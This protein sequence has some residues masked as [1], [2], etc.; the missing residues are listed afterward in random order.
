[1]D[2]K[3]NKTN[4]PDTSRRKFMTK[5]ALGAGATAAAVF[6]ERT[7]HAADS[8]EAKPIKVPEEF[9][10]ATKVAPVKPNFPMT[11]AQV[12]ARVCKEEG[13]A[14]LFCCPGNYPIQNA[15]A[16]EGIPTYSGRHEGGMCHA[17]DGF[18]RVTGLL[19]PHRPIHIS[20]HKSGGAAPLF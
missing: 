5:A 10:A 9:A 17:A 3:K 6:S 13:L 20:A 7:A 14:A 1:M 4:A 18:C 2:D 19:D 16:L 12:F 15:I 8:A 11:G